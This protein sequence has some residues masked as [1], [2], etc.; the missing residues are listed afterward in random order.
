M[1]RYFHIFWG[2]VSFLLCIKMQNYIINLEIPKISECITICKNKLLHIVYAKLRT[3]VNNHWP[4]VIFHKF[5]N[6]ILIEPSEQV[7]LLSL[8]F[9][10]ENWGPEKSQNLFQFTHCLKSQ[11]NILD[12]VL[13]LINSG[14][15]YYAPAIH[16]KVFM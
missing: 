5:T 6:L 8:F 1:G 13:Q 10:W 14:L 7:L 9:K 2:K 15:V 16:K 4:L 12:K 3:M 11:N